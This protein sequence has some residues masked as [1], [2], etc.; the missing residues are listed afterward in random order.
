[1]SE[2]DLKTLLERLEPVE[3]LANWLKALV[4]FVAVTAF[5]LGAWSAKL[6]SQVDR[7][8]SEVVRIDTN[9]TQAG[10]RAKDQIT[11]QLSEI[12]EQLARIEER[13]KQR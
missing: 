5:T 1:M 9:G 7:V 6:Q 4:V 3:K 10:D 8:Q 2:M 11:E 12:K 13:Q